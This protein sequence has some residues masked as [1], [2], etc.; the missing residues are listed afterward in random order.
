MKW[1]QI[2]PNDLRISKN[3]S[4]DQWEGW[5]AGGR[6]AAGRRRLEEGD[7]EVAA[8]GNTKLDQIKTS[9]SVKIKSDQVQTSASNIKSKH[10]EGKQPY[11][12]RGVQPMYITKRTMLNMKE[13]TNKGLPSPNLQWHRDQSCNALT[14]IYETHKHPYPNTSCQMK[15]ILSGGTMV[16]YDGCNSWCYC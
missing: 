10:I 7:G 11:L 5:P 14:N 6:G 8:S 12:G 2:G 3:T 9:A 16:R 15:E 13:S 4:F 1:S